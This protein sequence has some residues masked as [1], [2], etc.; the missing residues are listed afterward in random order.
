MTSA[1]NK[2]VFIDLDG[3]LT[4]PK[5]GIVKSIGHAL[6]GLGLPSIPEE[7]A[8]TWCIGPP[9]QQS[10]TTLLGTSD[11]ATIDR[12]M[13][14]YRERFGAV[15]LFENAVYPEVPAMLEALGAA[16]YRLFVATSK[17]LVYAARIVAHFGLTRRFERVFGAELDGTRGDKSDLLR[18][19]MAESKTA[20]REAVMIGDRVHDA[21]GART[22]GMRCLLVAWGYG[23]ADEIAQAPSDGICPTPADV[24]PAVARL[25]A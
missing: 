16:D 20:P 4:D 2:S 8:L 7:D 15:G 21:I 6:A 19:A 22:V 1:D 25:F 14:L 23:A 3:T 5:P 11:K 13:A 9:L 10:F 18:Y 24:P 17:P 12:A